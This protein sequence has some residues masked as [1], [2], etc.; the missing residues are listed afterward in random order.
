MFLIFKLNYVGTCVNDD[1]TETVDLFELAGKANRSLRNRLILDR[2]EVY[3][4]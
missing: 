2:S 4:F 3:K 1:K